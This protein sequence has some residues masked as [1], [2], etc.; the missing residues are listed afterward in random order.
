MAEQD[1]AETSVSDAAVPQD[2]AAEEGLTLAVRWEVPDS[3]VS[4]YVNHMS[5][6]RSEQ[7]YYLSF[8][9]AK[10]PLTLGTGEEVLA[11]LRELGEVPAICVAQLIVSA[12]RLETFVK[13][14]QDSLTR[15][16][17]PIIDGEG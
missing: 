13:V 5:V 16:A 17:V 9:E 7:N 12:D 3:I 1:S 11:K 2:R 14:L 8:Y 10:P 15:L 6:Q 4:R